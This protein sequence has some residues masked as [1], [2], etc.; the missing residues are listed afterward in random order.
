MPGKRGDFT[1]KAV[2]ALAGAAAA[3]VARK[4]IVFGWRK[5]TGAEP[6]E[7]DTEQETPLGQAL[8]WA[9]LTGAGVAAARVLA[10][11]LAHSRAHRSVEQ[12]P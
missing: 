3:Y 8:A 7:K 5:V 10:T 4:V 11:R 6:P 1:M 12:L 9:I 2:D